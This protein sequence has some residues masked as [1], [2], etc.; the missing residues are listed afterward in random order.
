MI[1]YEDNFNYLSKMCL[2]RMREAAFTMSEAARRRD[3]TVLVCGSDASDHAE[4]YL[5]HGADFVLIGEGEE[6]MCELM[7]QL[8]GRNEEPLGKIA[9]L[10]FNKE[11]TGEVVRTP[12]RPVIKDLDALPEPAWDLVDVPRYRDLWLRHHGYYSMNMV[13]TRGCPYHCNW[14]AKPI[15]GQTY[16]VRHPAHVADRTGPPEADIRPRPHLVCRRHS[17]APRGLDGTFRRRTRLS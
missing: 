9:G 6:T 12:P 1:L 4:E 10:A 13:T 17:G 16:H 15:W 5:A 11:G 7:D 3:C 8:D 14:C 2:L